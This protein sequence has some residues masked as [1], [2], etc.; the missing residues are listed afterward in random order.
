MACVHDYEETCNRVQQCG[1]LKC[2]LNY[3][4]ALWHRGGDIRLWLKRQY[5]LVESIHCWYVA[6]SW[7][8]FIK[9]S[10]VSNSQI[11]SCPSISNVEQ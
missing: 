11:F 7:D 10:K 4:G 2:D 9:L 8:S 1:S 5:L 6:F 3:N